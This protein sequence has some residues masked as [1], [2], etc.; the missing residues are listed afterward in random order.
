MRKER[1][2]GVR[3]IRRDR[4]DSWLFFLALSVVDEFI[5]VIT[6]LFRSEI[7]GE[8]ALDSEFVAE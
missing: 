4:I 2:T 3:N 6:Y 5:S 7:C 1:R 8:H